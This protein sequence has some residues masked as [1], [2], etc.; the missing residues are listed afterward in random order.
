[1]PR[2]PLR[3]VFLIR[4]LNYGGSERQLLSLTK[5]LLKHGVCVT[6]ATFY[7]G[8]K[9]ESAFESSGVSV[10]SLEKRSRWDIFGFSLRLI[11]MMK[12]IQPAILHGYLPT[13]NI[14]TVL[15]KL[16][17]PSSKII[18]G[19]RASDMKLDRYGLVDQVQS[20]IESKLSSFTD[21]VI[22]NSY[23]GLQ[24]AVRN[25]F[26]QDKMTVIPNGIDIDRFCP[27]PVLRR[28]V[29]DAWGLS[30]CHQWIG[31]VGRLDPMK[32]HDTFIR[33]AV[34]LAERRADVKYF[35][36]G[37]GPQTFKQELI[38]LSEEL[39]LGP[40]L[41]W[42]SAVD[43][44]EAIYNALDL[45][46]SCSSYGEGF[47]N[48]IGESMACGKFCVVTDVGDA[49]QIVGETGYVVPSENPGALASAWEIALSASH[50]EKMKRCLMARERIREHFSVQRL[51]EQT[52]RI[53]ENLG[54]GEYSGTNAR[55]RV[56]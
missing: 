17:C 47:S 14:L 11:R 15:L 25:G 34:I 38:G 45:V 49:K 18:W 32:G 44:V 16:F 31:I 52:I 8:G 24:F 27:N 12:R 56:S 55:Y 4:S 35:C 36:V 1:M 41:S 3:V 21:A 54:E 26:P 5:E 48:V 51:V 50:D 22:V 23:A 7:K 2:R 6:V 46:T 13:A 19:V 39:G 53:L 10:E 42:S 29:R 40:R 43:D 28:R 37:D 30:D 33:A 20:W 9:L